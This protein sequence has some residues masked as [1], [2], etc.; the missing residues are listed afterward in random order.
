M[1]KLYWR[2]RKDGKWTWTAA[3]ESNTL[4]CPGITKVTS[5]MHRKEEE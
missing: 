3:T 5:L 4:F 2:V 1:A